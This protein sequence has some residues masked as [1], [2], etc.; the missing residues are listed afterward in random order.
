V[1]KK[2]LIENIKRINVNINSE[3]LCFDRS[4][5][6]MNYVR[7]E[8]RDGYFSINIYI[9]KNSHTKQTWYCNA[10]CG[11]KIPFAERVESALLFPV[12]HAWVIHQVATAVVSHGPKITTIV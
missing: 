9:S 6:C 5:L 10:A 7:R 4:Q 2:D 8:E 1:K 12:D 3:E 11:F